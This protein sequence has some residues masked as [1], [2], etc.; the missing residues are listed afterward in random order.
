M[1]RQS[2]SLTGALGSVSL[3]WIGWSVGQIIIDYTDSI[4]TFAA[5]LPLLIG[6]IILWA[7]LWVAY[8]RESR[9]RLPEHSQGI[10]AA[11]DRDVEDQDSERR[12]DSQ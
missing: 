8:G 6:Q 9:I 12:E 1:V 7:L 10:F 3:S 4:S 2:A 5:Q 11:S